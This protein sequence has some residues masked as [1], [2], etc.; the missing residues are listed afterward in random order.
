V[1]AATRIEQ[2][3]F[4]PAKELRELLEGFVG[5][6]RIAL[7]RLERERTRP[8]SNL[9]PA[10][11]DKTLAMLTRRIARAERELARSDD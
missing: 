3:T 5:T 7:A 6:C 11:I 9:S 8:G 4:E 2:P 1:R 10:A